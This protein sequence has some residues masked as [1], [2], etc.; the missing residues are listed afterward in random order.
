ME[1]PSPWVPSDATLTRST[2]APPP[3]AA[4]GSAAAAAGSAIVTAQAATAALSKER[5]RLGPRRR[6]VFPLMFPPRIRDPVPPPALRRRATD[7]QPGAALR[8]QC[9]T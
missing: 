5:G 7:S 4:P 2:P 3:R 1:S 8:G 9:V 6:S